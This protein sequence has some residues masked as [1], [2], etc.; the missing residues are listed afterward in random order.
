MLINRF[1]TLIPYDDDDDAHNRIMAIPLIHIFVVHYHKLNTDDWGKVTP[2]AH[3]LM[4]AHFVK[5]VVGSEIFF[6]LPPSSPLSVLR[7]SISFL[8]VAIMR[9]IPHHTCL[10][11]AL[12]TRTY[13]MSILSVSILFKCETLSH[14]ATHR[15]RM[16]RYHYNLLMFY[17]SFCE[18]EFLHLAHYFAFAIPK[19]IL[20]GIF[21]LDKETQSCP[22]LNAQIE[23]NSHFSQFHR[24]RTHTQTSYSIGSFYQIYRHIIRSRSNQGETATANNEAYF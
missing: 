13:Q 3:R 21:W 24:R 16:S 9:N 5:D 14:F 1:I 4:H 2:K 15:I 18:L 6:F 11:G 10:F 20:S 23:I 7:T 12:D 22:C 17:G 8:Y 19:S